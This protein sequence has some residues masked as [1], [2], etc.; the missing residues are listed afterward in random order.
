MWP[1]LPPVWLKTTVRVRFCTASRVLPLGPIRI[2]RSEPASWISTVSPSGRTTETVASRPSSAVSCDKKPAATSPCWSRST[3]TSGPFAVGSS[4]SSL[5]PRP[6]SAARA[7]L[8]PGPPGRE[9][10]RLRLR[11]R[12]AG[13]EAAALASSPSSASAAGVSSGRLRLEE[14]PPRP[15][16]EGEPD[17]DEEPPDPVAELPDPEAELPDPEAELPERPLEAPEAGWPPLA[18]RRRSRGRRSSLLRG[19]VG[20]TR[21]RT[22]AS[23]RSRPNR[24][25]WASASTS[26]SASA[27]STPSS[28]SA[29]SLA[30]CT[31]RPVVSTHSMSASPAL[32]VGAVALRAVAPAA[33]GGLGCSAGLGRAA[34]AGLGRA[35]AR[36]GPSRAPRGPPRR[37][38]LAV[39]TV[40]PVGPGLVLGVLLVLL[41]LGRGGQQIPEPAPPGGGAGLTGRLGGRR[42]RGRLWLVAAGWRV[43][44]PVLLPLVDLVGQ[45][46]HLF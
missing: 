13:P 29:L 25:V 9:P 21:A 18:R 40:A 35:S 3:S 36:R 28:S 44:G 22:R 42:G 27:S 31:V 23:L 4:S 7:G 46:F 1:L 41:L 15:G 14:V 20:R 32:A 8:G 34:S 17:A 5:P 38:P 10:P 30:S 37:A 24:P 43:A 12:R 2:P 6:A 11:R 33:A 26:N 16:P 45:L 19:A 39:G